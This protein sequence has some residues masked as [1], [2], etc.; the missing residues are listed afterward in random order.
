MKL[1]KKVE[2]FPGLYSVR[3]WLGCCHVL[4]EDKEVVL[5]DT[6]LWGEHWLILRLLRDLGLSPKNIRAIL[7]THGHLDHTGNLHPLVQLSQ[8]AV[9]AH[10]GEQVH[11]DGHFAYRQAARVCGA[12]EAVGR[13]TFRYRPAQITHEFKNGEKLPF[14]G[15][16]KVVHL[17]GHTSGHCGFFSEKH[18]LLFSGDLFASYAFSVHPPPAILNSDPRQMPSAVR[19]AQALQPKWVLPNHYDLVDPDLHAKRL[20]GIR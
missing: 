19:K 16:L 20:A 2:T 1:V 9:Y 13:F 12:M 11:V 8:A 6:G 7:L 10:T 3:G 15:G 4:I 5:I 18:S 17:P 14:W